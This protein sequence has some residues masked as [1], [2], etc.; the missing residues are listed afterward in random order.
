MSYY[1]KYEQQTNPCLVRA[2]TNTY[3]YFRSLEI[4]GCV[5]GVFVAAQRRPVYENYDWP[6]QYPFPLLIRVDYI[7]Q[8]TLLLT[9]NMPHNEGFNFSRRELSYNC[10]EHNYP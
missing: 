5:R 1:G 8:L 7:L 10:T 3:T 2:C 9:E 4:Y 6:G